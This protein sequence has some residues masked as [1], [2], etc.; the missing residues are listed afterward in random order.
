VKI[1]LI[2]PA[3]IIKAG[4]IWKNINRALPPLGL[5]AIGA[6]L[7]QKGFTVKIL[8]VGA[9]NIGEDSLREEMK[10]FVPDFTG[11]TSTTV[12]IDAALNIASICKDAFP[13]TKIVFGGVHPTIAPEEVLKNDF[14]DYVIRRE[15]EY[16][17]H[18]LAAQK[19]LAGILGL[20]YK[21]NG[22]ILHNAERPF[23]ADLD[24]LP[25]PAYH[26]LPIKNYRPSTANYKRLPAIS[27]MSSRGCP[28]RC[29]FCY[30][31][32]C[33]TVTR[34]RS[35]ARIIEEIEFLQRDYGIREISFYDDT[36]TA[37]R[38]NVLE[39]CA[40]IE[41]KKIDITFSCMSRIDMVDFELLKKLKRAGCHQIGYG[42]ESASLEIM[43]NI[44]KPVS[45][46]KVHRVFSDTRRAGL[47]ARGMF[48]FGNPGETAESMAATLRLALS[49]KC[50][51]AVF[52]ITTPYPGT[53]MFAWAKK[54]GF[55]LTEDWS[56]YDL[57]RSV[58]RL[59][60]V[61]PEAVNSF[62]HYAYKRFY[63]RPGFLLRRLFKMR[64]L[65]DL[66]NNFDFFLGM[67]G[68]GR[69]K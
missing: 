51:M 37:N 54:N 8:D 24:N 60:T 53:E 32:T 45:L 49:L 6:F 44:K 56:R 66:K 30:T 9:Q 58:M 46:E 11:I 22:A 10:N 4:N 35:P 48:M 47:D 19:P 12:L 28:G 3:H 17:F 21:A 57:S 36:F 65:G 31:G 16:A 15:G 55:L 42:V 59:P 43:K 20:S 40:L 23:I 64:S 62:Y 63:L 69:K 18:E 67:L 5:A 52:N 68:A 1:L 2:S 29:T 50:D 14:V 26:L 41:K 38:A 39:L 61:S 7:E 13:G 33:G 27:I 34:F 25:H